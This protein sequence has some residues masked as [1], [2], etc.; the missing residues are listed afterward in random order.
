M[1]RSALVVD[2]NEEGFGLRRDRS[3]HAAAQNITTP[4]N[5]RR[6]AFARLKAVNKFS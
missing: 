4:S 1:L 2:K 3:A 6:T 5:M